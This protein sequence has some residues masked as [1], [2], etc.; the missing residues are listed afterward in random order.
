VLAYVESELVR[1]QLQDDFVAG[2]LTTTF[3]QKKAK[4]QASSAKTS[5]FCAVLMI[6]RAVLV[7]SMGT[8]DLSGMLRV[9][10]P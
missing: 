10:C 5:G 2:I 9:S 1:V 8:D 4:R 3:L 7:M 6:A